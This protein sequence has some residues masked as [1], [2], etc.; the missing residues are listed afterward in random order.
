M[1]ITLASSHNTPRQNVK[2]HKGRSK[3]ADEGIVIDEISQTARRRP[4]TTARYVTGAGLQCGQAYGATS[5]STKGRVRCDLH[6]T[7]L[8]RSR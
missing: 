8:T 5:G 3:Q 1:C 7:A 6:T 2:R 4:N